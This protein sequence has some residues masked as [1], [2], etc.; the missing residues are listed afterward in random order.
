MNTVFS[1]IGLTMILFNCYIYGISWRVA[2]AFGRSTC[3]SDSYY[4]I[5]PGA[6]ATLIHANIVQVLGS[7]AIGSFLLAILIKLINVLSFVICPLKMLWFKKNIRAFWDL[8]D[9]ITQNRCVNS[10][11]QIWS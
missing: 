8:K 9:I 4:E 5:L 2:A 6:Y 7:F 1:Y 10:L 11:K 3:P